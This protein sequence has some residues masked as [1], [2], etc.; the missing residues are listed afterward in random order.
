MSAKLCK[1]KNVKKCDNIFTKVNRQS[2][3]VLRCN[4]AIWALCFCVLN[5]ANENPTR[6]G[7]WKGIVE[8]ITPLPFGDTVTEIFPRFSSSSDIRSN[9]VRSWK[10]EAHTWGADPRS[11]VRTSIE[12]DQMLA[13]VRYWLV[14]KWLSLVMVDDVKLFSMLRH[15]IHTYTHTILNSLS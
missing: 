7:W 15:D 3:T 13:G 5:S 8:P 10:L 6:F 14:K 12:C 1:T 4:P 9:Y 11:Y 2:Q